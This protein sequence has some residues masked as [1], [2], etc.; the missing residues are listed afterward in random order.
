[1]D[2][3]CE[4]RIRSGADVELVGI[5]TRRDS[6]AKKR[7]VREVRASHAADKAWHGRHDWA[8]RLIKMW[9]W[10][11]WPAHVAFGMICPG[12]VRLP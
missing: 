8:W 7:Y 9:G 2:V 10:M 3:E 11:Q 5:M 6:L 1:M 4:R 12:H